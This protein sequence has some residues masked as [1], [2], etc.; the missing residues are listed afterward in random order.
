M[1]LVSD[2]HQLATASEIQR[3]GHISL[4]PISRNRSADLLVTA[5]FGQPLMQPGADLF[6]RVRPSPSL[7]SRH[8]HSPG[9]DAD[10]ARQADPFP[11]AAHDHTLGC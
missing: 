5:G 8:Q 4:S 3:V 9:G 10:D 1:L 7:V 6:G 2:S 11:N